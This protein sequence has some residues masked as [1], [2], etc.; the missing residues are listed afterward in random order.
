MLGASQYS[1]FGVDTR[2]H[3]GIDSNAYYNPID[4]GFDLTVKLGDPK[5]NREELMADKSLQ[6]KKLSKWLSCCKRVFDRDKNLSA[7]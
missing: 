7:R 2:E 4:P 5:A 1:Y 3:V 6:K